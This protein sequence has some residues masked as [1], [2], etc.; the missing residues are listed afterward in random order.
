MTDTIKE[1]NELDNYSKL[2]ESFEATVK[3]DCRKITLYCREHN[4]ALSELS[5]EEIDQFIIKE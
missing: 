1:H 2:T 5:Q 4:K 3:Y